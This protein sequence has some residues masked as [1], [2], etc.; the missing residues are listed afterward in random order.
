MVPSVKLHYRNKIL[1]LKKHFGDYM[2]NKQMTIM[3]VHCNILQPLK[4]LSLNDPLTFD[5]R[6]SIQH[7]N[8]QNNSK[9]VFA[10]VIV[11]I[12][13]WLLC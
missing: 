9:N 11:S 12:A 7:S 6:F 4:T 1:D 13:I 5:K 10:N 3:S 2:S 8:N